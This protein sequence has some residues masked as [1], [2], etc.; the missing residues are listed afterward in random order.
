[1]NGMGLSSIKYEHDD[2]NDTAQETST[3]GMGEKDGDMDMG[4]LDEDVMDDEVNGIDG[5]DGTGFGGV[6]A[7]GF[8]AD[9][10][11]SLATRKQS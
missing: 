5:L 6:A 11:E 1:M 3:S 10:R 7:L 2:D 8:V 4:E 9:L